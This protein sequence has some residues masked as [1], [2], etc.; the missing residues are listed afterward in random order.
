[1]TDINQPITSILP[2]LS[3][4]PTPPTSSPVG[5]SPS[6]PPLPTTPLETPQ[7]A[8]VDLPQP[9]QPNIAPPNPAAAG[10]PPAETPGKVKPKLHFSKNAFILGALSIFLVSGLVIAGYLA[11]S[12]KSTENRSQAGNNCCGDPTYNNGRD[13]DCGSETAS[14][15]AGY[16]ACTNHQCASCQGT[17]ECGNNKCESGE[18]HNVCPNDCTETG[19][20]GGNDDGGNDDGGNGGGQ[21]V[22]GSPCEDDSK[23]QSG[24]TCYQCPAGTGNVNAG[25]KVCSYGTDAAHNIACTTGQS[26]PDNGVCVPNDVDCTKC[27]DLFGVVCGQNGQWQTDCVRAHKCGYV[28]DGSNFVGCGNLFNDDPCKNCYKYGN[29]PVQCIY[30]GSSC[31]AGPECRDKPPETNPPE[32]NPPQTNTPTPTPTPTPVPKPF[33][34]KDL[35]DNK[36]EPAIGQKMLLTC[37]PAG[38]GLDRVNRY[39]FRYRI[40]DGTGFKSIAPNSKRS[41]KAVLTITK[42]GTYVVQCR[43]CADTECSAWDNLQK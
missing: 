23:C 11:T 28:P 4:S 17:S 8:P 21:G 27:G 14:W 29:N 6:L 40:N 24:M 16:Y 7:T 42:P 5:P 10:Q 3:A 36:P 9:P 32:T 37:T 34:C 18:D 20:D 1:M 39:E 25:K 12:S 41:N 2:P 19:G 38:A 22:I 35:T 26:I 30:E 43:V 13:G 15:E 31:G 33:R